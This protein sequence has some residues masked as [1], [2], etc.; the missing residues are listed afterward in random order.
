MANSDAPFGLKPIGPIISA[1]LYAVATAYGTAI[2]KGDLMEANGTS[3]ATGRGQL[4]GCGVEEEGAA[5]S[6]LG[7]CLGLYDSNYI[8]LMYMPASTTG[9][10]TIAGY[11]LIADSPDQRYVAQEDGDTTPIAAASIGLNAD[12][13]STHTGNNDTGVSKM[14]IDSNTVNT[15]ST[16]ALKVLDVYEDDEIASAY[17]RFICKL[18]A[19]HRGANTAGV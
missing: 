19:A 2:Y 15:T 9:N 14:E 13:I 1:N 4:Q 17:C 16:L 11:A 18:N 8:P 12:M 7:A 6:L 3:Y 5:G 10:S